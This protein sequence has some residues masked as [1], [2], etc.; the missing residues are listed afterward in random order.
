VYVPSSKD[1]WDDL[2]DVLGIHIAGT[3]AFVSVDGMRP[4]RKAKQIRIKTKSE[5]IASVFLKE[6]R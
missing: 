6:L 1:D 2:E 5:E 4:R 3:P